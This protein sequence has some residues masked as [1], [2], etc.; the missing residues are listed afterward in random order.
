MS[1]RTHNRLAIATATAT[2]LT[3]GLLSLTAAGTATAAAPVKY[4][5]Y[6]DDYNG[7][8]FRDYVVSQTPGF[9]VT[10]GVSGGPGTKKTRIDQNSPGIPGSVGEE[11]EQFGQAL[12]SADFNRDGYGDLAVGDSSETVSGRANQGAV[13]IVWGSKSGLGSKA[14]R[15]PLKDPK[16]GQGFGLSLAAGDFNGDKEP[17]LAVGDRDSVHV[18]RGGFSSKTGTTGAVTRHRPGADGGD[19]TVPVHLVAGNVTKDKTADLYAIGLSFTGQKS[20][21][22]AWFLKGGSKVA[23]GKVVTY[24]G[25]EHNYG[26]RGVIADFDR[27]GY[28]DL[29]INNGGYNRGEG[30]VVV[31]RGGASGP[32]TSY[33]VTQNT[34]GV[35]TTAT[36]GDAFGTTVSAGDTDRD[37][38]PDLA[39]SAPGEKVSGKKYAGGVHILRGGEKGLTGAGSKWF[40]R[41]TAGVP[42]KASA[43][44]SFGQFTRLRD[45]DNDRDADLVVS[46]TDSTSLLLPG[47]K[48]GIGTKGARD[49]AVT[50]MWPQ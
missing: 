35:A 6:A 15:L 11:P 25:P 8:G 9:L 16:E 27:N 43:W 13:T 40:T 23:S 49:I 17:D 24:T 7:D 32:S 36:S 21:N 10:Y 18:Y 12:A 4:A 3:C 5:Q 50:A 29:A 46:G 41:D 38:Y 14:T 45:I 37:G 28:G 26:P 47:G 22:V 2:A 34:A 31:L 30:A 19:R 44:G 20:S 33:R 39:A 48:N 42:G 1:R